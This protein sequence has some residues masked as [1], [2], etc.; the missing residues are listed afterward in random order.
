MGRNSK[1]WTDSRTVACCGCVVLV[2]TAAGPR[3]ATAAPNAKLS[4]AL[5]T[6]AQREFDAGRF[7]RAAELFLD[8]WRQDDR[9]AVALYN[10]A[11]SFHLGGILER[12]DGVYRE[13][14]ARAK[15]D[16]ATEAKVR[17][18]M[19]DVDRRRAQARATEAVRAEEAGRYIV[20]AQLWSEA[21]SLQPDNPEFTLKEGR[22]L[23]L[24]GDITAAR[25]RYNRYLAAAPPDDPQRAVAT[26]W[27]TALDATTEAAGAPATARTWAGWACV[28]AGAGAGGAGLW[29]VA[30]AATATDELERK[31]ATTD[32][33]GKITG[34][35][36]AAARVEAD[37]IDR[38]FLLGW[39]SVGVGVAAGAIGAWL[40]ATRPGAG[41]VVTW[42][43]RAVGVAVRF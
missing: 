14:L 2:G 6:A 8:I 12:A 31:L 36:E 17:N 11:R 37:R 32:A 41:A 19:A 20:A 34:I 9:A 16:P 1:W 10:A 33:A 13:F 3:A 21:G 22:A 5:V 4:D 28:V 7:E 35:G 38:Q 15:P 43:P 23:H 18:H 26:Q 40:L 24:G 25:D 29:F 27:Q 39:S 42:G 30:G